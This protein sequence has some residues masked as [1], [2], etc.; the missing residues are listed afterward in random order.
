[1]YIAESS[2]SGWSNTKRDWNGNAGDW[3]LETPVS[4]WV[5]WDFRGCEENEE[6]IANTEN[7][8]R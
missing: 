4:G 5:E 2:D 3:E 8:E 7:G 1:M 6:I